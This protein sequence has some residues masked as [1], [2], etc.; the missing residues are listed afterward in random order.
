MFVK[1]ASVKLTICYHSLLIYATGY[2]E[3][4]K[5]SVFSS[6]I[7]TFPHLVDI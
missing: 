7:F 1:I 5:I 2:V 3:V 6:F 4:E